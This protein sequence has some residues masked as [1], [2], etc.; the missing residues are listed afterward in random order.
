M[1]WELVIVSG[2]T[3]TAATVPQ[4]LTWAQNRKRDEWER[5]R[6]EADEVRE[7]ERARALV[8]AE[9]QRQATEAVERC[10][11]TAN[12]FCGPTERGYVATDALN[13]ALRAIE[14]AVINDGVSDA[15][16]RILAETLVSLGINPHAN[17]GNSQKHLLQMRQRLLIL[18][19]VE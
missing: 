2:I 1:D 11:T 4:V 6:I 3:A 8:A 13:D 18:T 19:P 15:Q 14:S 12:A 16:R 17:L 7:L 10:L 9:R 5:K